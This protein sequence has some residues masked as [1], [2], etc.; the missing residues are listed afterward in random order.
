MNNNRILLK[1]VFIPI[2]L[3]SLFFISACAEIRLNTVPQ[4]NPSIKL[5]IFPLAVTES[6]PQPQYGTFDLT[7]EEFQKESFA[8]MERLLNDT[9]IYEVTAP[10][11]IQAVLGDRDIPF[12]KWRKDDFDLVKKAARILH[13]DYA[14]LIVRGIKGP[15]M[16]YM[17]LILIGMEKD[18]RYEHSTMLI[19]APMHVLRKIRKESIKNSIPIAYRRIFFDAKEDLLETAMRKMHLITAADTKKPSAKETTLASAQKPSIAPTVGE[20]KKTA[21]G[22]EHLREPL[23][24][25][26]ESR[27]SVPPPA[28]KPVLKTP[29][30]VKEAPPPLQKS[31]PEPPLPSPVSTATGEDQG[32]APAGENKRRDFEKQLEAL[33]S[34]L[35]SDGKAKLVVH[36]FDSTELLR[37]VSLILT[38]ALREEL[39]I[40]G[41]FRL[42]NRENMSQ[43]LEELKLQQSGLIDEKQVAQLGKWLAADQAVTGRL[44]VLANTSLL[45]AKLTNIQDMETL[46]LGSLTCA[47]GQEDKMLSGMADLAGRLAGLSAK[48]R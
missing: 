11:E 47:A 24:P 12:W 37:V 43:A 7:D 39:F 18:R 38:E 44:S 46:G 17:S 25:A 45:Q 21:P 23:P 31:P 14:I 29:D 1:P 19:S 9:A 28:M 10:K 16:P 8:E 13:A 32:T 40:L 48:K 3:S 22:K 15:D 4:P 27:V 2:I 36:D 35:P 6:Q 26:A 41:R 34:G 33:Q 5:R 42:V 30:A 20:E